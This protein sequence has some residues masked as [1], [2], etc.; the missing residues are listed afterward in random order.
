MREITGA[1]A[2]SLENKAGHSSQSAD[3]TEQL[4]TTKSFT[5]L[6]QTLKLQWLRS[7]LTYYSNSTATLQYCIKTELEDPEN[8]LTYQCKAVT[9]RLS[10]C[11]FALLAVMSPT[12][13]ITAREEKWI[14]PLVTPS[15]QTYSS[16]EVTI[17]HLWWTTNADYHHL[18]V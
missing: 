8:L 11:Y 4:E 14:P 18:L 12:G 13:G 1:V 16:L 17:N 3:S 5:D 9:E 10:A 2:W 15:Y 6:S 7:I